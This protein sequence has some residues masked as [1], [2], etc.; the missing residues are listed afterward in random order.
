MQNGG[1]RGRGR[2]RPP[3]HFFNKPGGC[4]K[5]DSCTFLHS[6][7]SEAAV[8]SASV[9]NVP[10]QPSRDQ[11]SHRDQFRGLARKASLGFKELQTLL[12]AAIRCLDERGDS[13]EAM[14]RALGGSASD[15]TENAVQHLGY[16]AS[17]W[18]ACGPGG[19]QVCDI[20]DTFP[21]SRWTGM[22][23]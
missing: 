6:A 4:R 9:S 21:H 1:G 20:V 14:C 7:V 12:K 18:K 11:F 3:C 13:S 23:L 16:I 19:S 2:G 10:Q 17:A 22:R 8:G 15:G 5:G